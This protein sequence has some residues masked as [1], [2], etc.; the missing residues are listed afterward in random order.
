MIDVFLQR[1][2]SLTYK[3]EYEELLRLIASYFHPNHYLCVISKRYLIQLS[4][5]AEEKLKYCRDLLELFDILDP[6]LSQTRGLT[7]LEM[8]MAE[9]ATRKLSLEEIADKKA[10]IEKCLGVEPEGSYSKKRLEY[11][12]R[13]L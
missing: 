12:R 7:M 8:T 13:W 10:M 6:G 11:L 3:E 5:K 9:A 1:L 2:Q 4:D